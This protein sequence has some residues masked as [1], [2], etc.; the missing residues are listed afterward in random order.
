MNTN[1]IEALLE[2]FYEGNTSLQEE[3]TLQDFFQREDVPAHL[4]PHQSL[5]GYYKSEQQLGLNNQNF[6]KSLS[7]QIKEDNGKISVIRLHPSRKGFLFLTGIAATILL[8]IGLLV[9]FQQDV[10]KRKLNQTG[11]P[12]VEIAYADASKALLLVSGN[13]NNGLKYIARLQMVDKAMKNMQLFN[14]FYQY[15]TM[16]INQDEISNQSVKPKIQ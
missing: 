6:E 15:Q 8:L 14:K 12:D 7:E 11:N 1:G 16:I 10:F 13:L 5:F 4:K 3:R 9:A 2:K